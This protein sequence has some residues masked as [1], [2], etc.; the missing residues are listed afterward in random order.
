MSSSGQQ[1]KKKET[2]KCCD[3]VKNYCYGFK[4]LFT[5]GSAVWLLGGACLRIAQSS[6]VGFFMPSYFKVYPE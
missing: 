3:M 2:A 1:V 4:L 5:N 6:I